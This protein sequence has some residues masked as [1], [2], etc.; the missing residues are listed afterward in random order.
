MSS[1]TSNRNSFYTGSCLCGAIHYTINGNLRD[2]VNCHCSL[3]RKFHGHFGA[4][5]AAKRK[6]VNIIDKEKQLTWYR[7]PGNQAQRG[8]CTRCGASLFWD[9]DSAPTLW[10]SAGTLEQPTG[11][12]TSTDIYVEDKAD[13]YLLDKQRLKCEQGLR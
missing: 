10:I 13:Y 8:F 1:T 6:D 3:C 4:Y 9:L 7:S 2:V 12:T 11:L 5:T